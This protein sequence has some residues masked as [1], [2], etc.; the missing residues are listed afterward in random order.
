MNKQHLDMLF[1][2]CLIYLYV[3]VLCKQEIFLIVNKLNVIKL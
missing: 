2:F 3:V 1:S